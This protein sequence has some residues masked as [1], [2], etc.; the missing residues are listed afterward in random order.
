MDYNRFFDT[1]NDGVT[2]RF[3][4]DFAPA[5]VVKAVNHAT[6]N[7]R[8]EYIENIVYAIFFEFYSGNL[9]SSPK[10]IENIVDSAKY[11]NYDYSFDFIRGMFNTAL[12]EEAFK[13]V[14]L[15]GEVGH[16]IREMIGEMA[17]NIATRLVKSLEEREAMFSDN[18]IVMVPVVTTVKTLVKA[19]SIERA[20]L[21]ASESDAAKNNETVSVFKF[22]DVEKV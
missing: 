6:L 14:E 5:W 2:Y 15:K 21:K 18:Y 9:D 1:N 20:R 7:Q 4:N 22:W 10:S 19:S 11:G 16:Y 13:T 17:K 3:N 12:W 8:N